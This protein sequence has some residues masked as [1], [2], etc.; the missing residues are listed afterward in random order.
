MILFHEVDKFEKYKFKAN[1]MDAIICFYYVDRNL[2]RR[3][4]SWLKPGGIL[5]YE[6]HT[7]YQKNVK[8]SEHYSKEYLL[9][10][11][12]LLGMFKKIRVLKYEEPMHL[13]NYTA[14]II[15]RKP[16]NILK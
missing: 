7:D 16:D 10:P 1:S 13:K 6:S 11:T 15:I 5:I 9:R 2:H 12:E 8:G 3:M 14:S 4:L